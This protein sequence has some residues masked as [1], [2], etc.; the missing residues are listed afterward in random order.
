MQHAIRV[1]FTDDS[2]SAAK[3]WVTR[4][5]SGP[6]DLEIGFSGI[7][8]GDVIAHEVW[9]LMCSLMSI[10][11]TQEHTWYELTSEIYAYNF[12]ALYLG[13]KR[14]LETIKL[15]RCAIEAEYDSK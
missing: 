5:A 4:F 8:T 13:V 6:V 1:V 9:H 2:D 7:P 15:F 12:Q 10:V 14:T 3:A 11:D